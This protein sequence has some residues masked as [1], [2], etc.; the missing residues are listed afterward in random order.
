MKGTV[1]RAFWDRLDPKRTVYQLGSTFEG[2][3]ERV[4]ELEAKGFVKAI[5]E[6]KPAEK[7]VKKT[8]ARKPAAR[9]RASGK[10]S[11]D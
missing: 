1:I 4:A 8:A 10:A 11:D 9:K 5:E 3:P 6:K 2:E 7:A